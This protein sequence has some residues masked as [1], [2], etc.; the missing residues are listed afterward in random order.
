MFRTRTICPHSPKQLHSRG[1]KHAVSKEG[2][3]LLAMLIKKK[4]LKS[5]NP[6]VI[7]VN[8]NIL[9]PPSMSPSQGSRK[10]AHRELLAGT[11]HLVVS[12]LQKKVTI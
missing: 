9:L 10:L 2:K 1:S 12:T 4:S 6:S 7:T 5:L 8:P 11:S 3:A